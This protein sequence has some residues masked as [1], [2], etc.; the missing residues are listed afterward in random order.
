MHRL[1]PIVASL[2]FL[3]AYP[4]SAEDISV[5]DVVKPD[6]RAIGQTQGAGTPNAIGAGA[7]VPLHTT[8]DAVTYVDVGAKAHL[9]D[10]SG[11]SSIINTDVAG[12]TLSTSTRIG[13]RWINDIGSWMYGVYGGNL[14][15]PVLPQ[16]Q[17]D[18]LRLHDC[19]RLS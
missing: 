8:S 16:R 3:G 9:D 14:L 12:A 10:R 17:G 5:G 7:F 15:T 6:I 2:L 18:V 4:I 11:D 1:T 19:W 13:Y